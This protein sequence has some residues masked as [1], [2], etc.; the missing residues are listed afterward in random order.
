MKCLNCQKQSQRRCL[1]RSTKAND[2]VNLPRDEKS[3]TEGGKLFQ[4]FITRLL[5]SDAEVQLLGNFFAS[6]LAKKVFSR[7][8][9]ETG[10]RLW[11]Y[12]LRIRPGQPGQLSLA[13]PPRVGAMSSSES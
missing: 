9:M 8:S 10:D 1:D 2:F 13:I 5:K 7:V 11:L 12:R 3:T 6:R 4:T